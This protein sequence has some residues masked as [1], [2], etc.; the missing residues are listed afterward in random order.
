MS[1]NI[2][3]RLLKVNP[4]VRAGEVYARMTDEERR[5]PVSGVWDALLDRA[6]HAGAYAA[7]ELTLALLVFL[8][9]IGIDDPYSALS[10]SASRSRATSNRD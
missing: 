4:V 3:K 2:R 9:E 8:W 6:P 5:D 10:H 7:V 1:E